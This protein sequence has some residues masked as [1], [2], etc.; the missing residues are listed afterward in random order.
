MLILMKFSKKTKKETRLAL[1]WESLFQAAVVWFH[2]HPKLA[3]AAAGGLSAL[4]VLM[5]FQTLLTEMGQRQGCLEGFVCSCFSNEICSTYWL[6]SIAT[7]SIV[8]GSH[9]FSLPPSLPPSLPSSLPPF[10]PSSFQKQHNG[11]EYELW[12]KPAWVWIWLCHSLSM[13][14]WHAF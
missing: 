10:L 3:P 6:F 9:P 2:C 7:V 4:W 13:W 1:L 5:V 12:G 8:N 14:L 11:E